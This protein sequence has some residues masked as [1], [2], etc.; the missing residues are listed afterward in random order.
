MREDEGVRSNAAAAPGWTPVKVVNGPPG[1]HDFPSRLSVFD[2]HY[3]PLEC[4]PLYD[5]GLGFAV[6]RHIEALFRMDDGQC[7]ECQRVS[8][9]VKSLLS[10][11]VRSRA[12][13]TTARLL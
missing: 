2:M 8:A 6:G 9:E 5:G 10:N 4:L 3:A 13:L 11:P 7:E 1:R 12:T